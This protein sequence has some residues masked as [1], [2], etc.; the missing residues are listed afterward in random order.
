MPRDDVRRRCGG[1]LRTLPA[2]FGN[3]SYAFGLPAGSELREPL[4][5]ALLLR[6]DGAAWRALL[7][8]YLGE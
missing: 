5:R 4:N 3:E 6:V 8:R 2:V 7:E 1:R